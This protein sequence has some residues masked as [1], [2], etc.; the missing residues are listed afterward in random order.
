[1]I[2]QKKGNGKNGN[3]QKRVLVTAGMIETW[4][5]GVRALFKQVVL[6]H[7]GDEDSAWNAVFEHICRLHPDVGPDD[8]EWPYEIITGKRDCSLDEAQRILDRFRDRTVLIDGLA[9]ALRD[10]RQA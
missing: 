10:G 1:M 9:A 6:L 3:G 5:S 7:D 8:R 4:Q 2:E